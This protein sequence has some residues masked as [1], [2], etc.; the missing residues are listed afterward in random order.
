MRIGHVVEQ[1]DL[2]DGAAVAAAQ[3]ELF[4]SAHDAG[5]GAN[6]RWATV[7]VTKQARKP[8]C[9]VQ[10][11]SRMKALMNPFG[12][13]EAGILCLLLLTTSRLN[14]RVEGGAR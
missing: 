3:Q 11:W 9:L 2:D 7:L 13:S 1:P 10:I 5:L 4:D 6:V 14:P 12:S 8:V